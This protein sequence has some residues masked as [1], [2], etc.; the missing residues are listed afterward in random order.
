MNKT[1]CASAA[2]ADIRDYTY[3]IV[4]P[5]TI[6]KPSA[7]MISPVPFDT[8]AWITVRL[9]TDIGK[10]SQAPLSGTYVI[11]C[12]ELDGYERYTSPIAISKADRDVYSAIANACPNLRGRFSVKQNKDTGCSF[13]QDCIAWDLKFYSVYGELNQF[14]ILSNEGYIME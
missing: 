7:T 6:S 8:S 14:E 12:Y 13:N 9:P 11:K 2:D 4:V 5:R 1:E 3:E 10:L